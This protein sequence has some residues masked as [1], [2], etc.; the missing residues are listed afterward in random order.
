MREDQKL[1][2]ELAARFMVAKIEKDGFSRDQAYAV[3]CVGLAA[4]IVRQAMA[5]KETGQ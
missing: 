5:E 3:N 1:I 2:V 4:T